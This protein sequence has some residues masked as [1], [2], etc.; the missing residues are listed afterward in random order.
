MECIQVIIGCRIN[1]SLIFYATCL[2]FALLNC[3]TK[4]T[5]YNNKNKIESALHFLIRILMGLAITDF[6]KA[7]YMHLE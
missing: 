5:A 6:K 4:I 2:K 1:S 3:V 7:V